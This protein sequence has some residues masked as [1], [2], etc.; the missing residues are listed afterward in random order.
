MGG[1]GCWALLLQWEVGVG[2]ERSLVGWLVG[3]QLACCHKYP[4]PQQE[5]PNLSGTLFRRKFLNLKSQEGTAPI[6]RLKRAQRLDRLVE[7]W[8]WVEDVLQ[9]PLPHY[10]ERESE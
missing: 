3:P 10:L 6:W 2:W 1:G 4:L 7:G 9:R 5:G 8:P